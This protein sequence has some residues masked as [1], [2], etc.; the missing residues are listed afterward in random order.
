MND[1]N[2]KIK[3]PFIEEESLNPWFQNDPD[4][5]LSKEMQFNN[6]IKK[7]NPKKFAPLQN[8]YL[9]IIHLITKNAIVATLIMIFALSGVGV[10]AAELFAPEQYK[11]SSLFR[12]NEENNNSK[13]EI[14]EISPLTADSEH[15]VIVIEECDLA[16][17]YPNTI[18]YGN[19][20]K[21]RLSDKTSQYNQSLTQAHSKLINANKHFSVDIV[22]GT[23]GAFGPGFGLDIGC[24][25]FSSNFDNFNNGFEYKDRSFGGNLFYNNPEVLGDTKIENI[26]KSQFCSE[27]EILKESCEI[28]SETTK[29]TVPGADGE[30]KY[31]YFVKNDKAYLID[32]GRYFNSP[33]LQVQFNSLAPS[34]P[35]VNPSQTDQKPTSDAQPLT[36]DSEHDVIVIEECDL[37]VRYAK[38][39]SIENTLYNRQTRYSNGKL[40]IINL[41]D[42]VLDEPSGT[43]ISCNQQVI[44]ESLYDKLL[45][46]KPKQEACVILNLTPPSCDQVDN[47]EEYLMTKN[48]T[49]NRNIL[50]KFDFN[51]K[52]YRVSL[53][54]ING[55]TRQG[56][57]DIQVQFNS[58]TPSTSSVN[59]SQTD[60]DT[61][62][63]QPAAA[64]PVTNVKSFTNPFYT[65]LKINYNN[66][67]K[68]ETTTKR[69]DIYPNLLERKVTFTKE[70]SVL[71]FVF[72]PTRIPSGCGGDSADEIVSKVGNFNKYKNMI[73]SQDSNYDFYYAGSANCFLSNEITTNISIEDVRFSDDYFGTAFNEYYNSQNI[74]TVR[75]ITEIT[76]K[77]S[78]PTHIQEADEIIKNSVLN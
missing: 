41:N 52:K 2:Y 13:E 42:E 35:S 64:Q 1:K 47:F 37:A 76:L 67:W 45:N 48:Y 26:E 30:N 11:P 8:T 25:N 61:T 20:L 17:R 72:S 70:N 62:N 40:S 65:N 9:K 32:L 28:I 36:A 15:D 53:G 59:P 74:K 29:I 14:Q 78:N 51:N 34:T 58:L 39:I 7:R 38:Q 5:K 31:Y 66:S 6:Y 56:L 77:S 60:S 63:S 21:I 18:E 43:D 69:Y 55:N 27:I 57:Q 4:Y 23:P 49:P 33:K 73:I 3:N 46:Q 22:D 54:Y 50:F 24:Y 12:N 19:K 10:G 71:E 44:N 16:V 68:M 75:Y